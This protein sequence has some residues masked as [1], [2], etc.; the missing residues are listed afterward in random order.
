MSR[1]LTSLSKL[2]C[3]SLDYNSEITDEGLWAVASGCPRLRRVSME[4]DEE[5]TAE[6]C[7]AVEELLQERA[8]DLPMRSNPFHNTW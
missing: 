3:L 8:D 7:A 4:D 2:V 1:A 6:G 5:I